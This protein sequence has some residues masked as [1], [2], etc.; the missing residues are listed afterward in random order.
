MFIQYQCLSKTE[1]FDIFRPELNRGALIEAD[2]LDG[3]CLISSKINYSFRFI[4]FSSEV[5]N[6][7][8]TRA[9]HTQFSSP[10]LLDTS[11]P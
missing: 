8:E 2:S 6:Y 9:V 3:Q 4:L 10:E 11:L 5:Q 7:H 1:I